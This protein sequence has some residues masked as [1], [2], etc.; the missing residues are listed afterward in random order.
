MHVSD[1]FIGKPGPASICEA[2]VAG[3]PVIVERNAFTMVQE[4]YNTDW[5]LQ[6]GVGMVVRSVGE[7]APAISSLLRPGRLEDLSAHARAMEIRAVFQIP[8]VLDR[9][10]SLSQTEGV[11]PAPL[12]PFSPGNF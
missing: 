4:R 2:I 11:P 1:Y 6:N 5:I 10:L 12:H 3:L 7:I 9:L 8:D